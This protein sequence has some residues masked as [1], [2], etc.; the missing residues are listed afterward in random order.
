[1]SLS[2]DVLYRG[3]KMFVPWPLFGDDPAGQLKVVR[4]ALDALSGARSDTHA[5]LGNVN[6]EGIRWPRYCPSRSGGRG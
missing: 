6:Q 5:T 4:E 1:M 3:E 2:P